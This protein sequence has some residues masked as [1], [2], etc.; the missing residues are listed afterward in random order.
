MGELCQFNAVLLAQQALVVTSILYVINLDRLV[1]LRGHAQLA[2]V[3]EIDRQNMWLRFALLKVIS[4]K[5]LQQVSNSAT[6]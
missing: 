1:A 3:V 5:Q 6:K 4:L 2:R